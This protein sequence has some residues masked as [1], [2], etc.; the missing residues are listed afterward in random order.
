MYRIVLYRITLYN[1][2]KGGRSEGLL[3]ASCHLGKPIVTCQ[4]GCEVS[5]N[6]SKVNKTPNFVPPSHCDFHPDALVSY[7]LTQSV[8]GVN[9]KSHAIL[10]SLCFL[11]T[12]DQRR[13]RV[14]IKKEVEVR[15]RR[16]MEEEKDDC[17]EDS[18]LL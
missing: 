16:R 8:A 15:P 7:L 17:S 1:L 2:K 10:H 13:P 18:L 6:G 4:N 5:Q 3:E 9:L 14:K 12:F 11:F